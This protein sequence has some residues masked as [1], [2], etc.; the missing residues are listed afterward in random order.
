MSYLYKYKYVLFN[1]LCIF[2]YNFK[3]KFHISMT[4]IKMR[5]M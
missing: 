3:L 5:H 2:S 4:Q 1:I